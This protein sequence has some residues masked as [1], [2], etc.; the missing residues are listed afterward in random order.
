MRSIL[1]LLPF[2]L[3]ACQS[4]QDDSAFDLATAPVEAISHGVEANGSPTV[5]QTAAVGDKP[6]MTVYKRSTCGCCSSWIDH[7]EQAGYTVE[8]IDRDADLHVV[9]DSLGLP[10]DLS[11]CHTGVVDG[12]V[13]EGHVPANQ[14][15][16]LL[17]DRPDAL[18]IAV[19]GMPIGS[20]GM[21]MGDQRDPYDVLIVDGNGE[22]AV[23]ASIPGNTGR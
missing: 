11:S 17:A 23:F 8:A 6:T 21:E 1:F 20:P 13:V 15:D 9:K 10:Q 16:R 5:V 2:A 18:G 7:V 4:P 12:Y 22:A 3:A 14:V 19:P